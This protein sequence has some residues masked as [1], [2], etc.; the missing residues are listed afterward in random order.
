MLRESRQ[1]AFVLYAAQKKFDG[2]VG[3][4]FNIIVRIRDQICYSSCFQV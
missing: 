2:A 3:A 4:F 1:V